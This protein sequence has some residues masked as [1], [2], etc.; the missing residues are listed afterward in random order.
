M[1]CCT[2]INAISIQARNGASEVEDEPEHGTPNEGAMCLCTMED[3]TEEDGNYGAFSCK[4]MPMI[5]I[6]L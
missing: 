2:R 6:I 4:Y 1:D 5:R 3:I